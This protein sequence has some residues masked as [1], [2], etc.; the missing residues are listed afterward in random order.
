MQHDVWHQPPSS[1]ELPVATTIE[2]VATCRLM[3]MPSMPI[4]TVALVEDDPGV[5]RQL[6]SI[7]KHAPGV[8]CLGTYANAEDA[9][10]EIPQL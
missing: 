5:R 7:L 9:M 2:I 3:T 8:A 4:V 1:A 10:R 6:A